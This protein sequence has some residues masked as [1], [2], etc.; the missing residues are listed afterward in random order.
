M[1]SINQHYSSVRLKV[2][3]RAGQL[4]QRPYLVDIVVQPYQNYAV[5][6][7]M[8]FALFLVICELLGK[9]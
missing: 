4:S 7:T 8:F 2:Y 5:Y 9:Q 6:Y 3:Q 1:L